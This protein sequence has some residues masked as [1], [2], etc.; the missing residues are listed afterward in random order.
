MFKPTRWIVPALAL[1]LVGTA[2]PALAPASIWG[3][4]PQEFATRRAAVRKAM[5]EAIV[6]LP[7][8]DEGPDVDRGRFRTENNLMYL[9]GVEA[10]GAVLALLPEND[11]SGKPSVLFLKDVPPGRSVWSDPVP[12]PN[13]ETK[14]STG[15]DELASLRT[16]WERLTPS[17]KAAK[18]VLMTG[19]VLND[20]KFK[21]E[22]ALIAKIKEINPDIVVE[23]GAQRLIN[24][25]RWIKSPG[26]IAN[27]RAAINATE[28]G[29]R[30]AVKMIKPGITELAVEGMILAGF[31]AGGATREGFPSI[32]GAGPNSTVLHHFSGDR[33]LGAS[34][35]VVCDIGA[36][37]NYYSADVTRTYPSNGKFTPRQ[38]ELYTLVLE[39]QRACEK[40][41]VPNKTTMGELH[42]YAQE[43]LRKSPLR[44][45]DRNG[46]ERTMDAFFV[47][48]LGH[49][50]GM[51]VHDVGG[52]NVYKPG[53]V[54]TI[55]PGVYVPSENI[56]IR[57]EDDYL[58][59]DKGVEKLSGSNP[60]DIPTIEA[61][62]KGNR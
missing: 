33:P 17:I 49:W 36:E 45:K 8:P 52:G 18:K 11:P 43:F 41:V 20:A 44:A 62:M 7:G 3:Q 35:T 22:G 19:S 31:R 37:Y 50:L 54:F 6:I 2:A 26:E 29:H 61:M 25:L 23:G 12:G 46:N 5:G 9:T 10:P 32:V 21:A 57:I 53:V 30:L 51:D 1:W 15:L 4:T 34:E 48:G 42:R 47:H 55:E 27:L 24:P 13:E 39:C 40:Y 58:V 14:S 56:G 60:S 16:M 38:R 59:T 28:R